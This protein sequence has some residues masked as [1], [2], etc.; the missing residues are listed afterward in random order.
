MVI[1]IDLLDSTTIDRTKIIGIIKFRIL[2]IVKMAHVDNTLGNI[3]IK[4]NDKWRGDYYLKDDLSFTINRNDAGRFYILK[5]GNTCILNGDRIS[6][7]LG[8]STLVIDT[9]DNLKL[10][11]REHI[12][13]EMSSFVISNGTDHTDPIS[14]ESKIFFVADRARKMALKYEWGM[15]LVSEDPVISG[16]M[17]YKPRDHPNLINSTYGGTCEAHI[18]S[19]QFA[20]E[21]ADAPITQSSTVRNFTYPN[22]SRDETQC[23]LDPTKPSKPSPSELFDGYKGAIMVLLLM[24]ILVLCVLANR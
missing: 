13:M 21:R 22:R 2:K 16:A 3:L 11:D 8:N 24:V 17:N 6:V 15:D 1:V 14:Y 4:H 7:H 19:F 10:L 23:S 9:N 12:N 18:N 20:L 5:S